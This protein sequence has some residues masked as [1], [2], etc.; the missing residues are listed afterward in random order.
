[1][2]AH[3]CSRTGASGPESVSTSVPFVNIREIR[4]SS[5]SYPCPVASLFSIACSAISAPVVVLFHLLFQ[6][7][8]LHPPFRKQQLETIVTI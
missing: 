4:G 5:S 7:K 8:I 6:F 1:M 3:Q 2:T